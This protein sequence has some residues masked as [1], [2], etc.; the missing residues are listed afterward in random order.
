MTR[1]SKRLALAR[2]A[3][4]SVA[5]R[6]STLPP[7]LEVEELRRRIEDCRRQVEGWTNGAPTV[8]EHESVMKHVLGLHTAVARLQREGST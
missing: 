4:E 3:I 5:Q 6:V 2:D 8:E 7:T 1:V